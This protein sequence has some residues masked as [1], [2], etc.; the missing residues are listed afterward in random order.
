[1]R[2]VIAVGG[3]WLVAAATGSLAWAFATLGVA[4]VVYGAMVL[5]AVH[6]GAWFRG[7]AQSSRP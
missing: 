5:G 7:S 4:L 1:V 3:G 6:A 2:L